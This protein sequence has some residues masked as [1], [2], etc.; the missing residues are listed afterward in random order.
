MTY[1]I[2]FRNILIIIIHSLDDNR[3]INSTKTNHTKIS[4]VM[5]YPYTNFCG[6]VLLNLFNTT[7]HRFYH[8]NKG[9]RSV[10]LGVSP[11]CVFIP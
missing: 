2:V 10:I 7:K 11:Q 3:V 6:A 9:K 8:S 5:V 1:I 4:I